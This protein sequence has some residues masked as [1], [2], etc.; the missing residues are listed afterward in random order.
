MRSIS[1]VLRKI[2]NKIDEILIVF[3][4]RPLPIVG[5]SGSRF[6]TTQS[7]QAGVWGRGFSFQWWTE[8]SRDRNFRGFSCLSHPSTNFHPI[9]EIED[10]L[11][12]FRKLF[13][14][15]QRAV[16][17]SISSFG[18]VSVIYPSAQVHSL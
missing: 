1:A 2:F 3:R 12:P 18:T 13:G 16:L 5:S 7:S 15:G 14:F 4:A 17:H 8:L 9:E 6:R 11:F 10:D